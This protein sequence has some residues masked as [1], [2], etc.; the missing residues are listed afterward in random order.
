LST[1]SQAK[2]SLPPFSLSVN[3]AETIGINDVNRRQ[4]SNIAN[5]VDLD[6]A[7]ILVAIESL[8]SISR[9]LEHRN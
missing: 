4:K 3:P 1:S 2:N 5:E 9:L 8:L 7:L 6:S